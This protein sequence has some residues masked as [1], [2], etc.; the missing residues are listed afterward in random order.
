MRTISRMSGVVVAAVVLALGAGCSSSDDSAGSTGA[1]GPT[2]AAAGGGDAEGNCTVVSA[3]EVADITGMEVTDTSELPTGCQWAVGTTGAT[4]EW[5]SIPA[6]TYRSNLD[7]AEPAG[8]EVD[9]LNGI[10]AEGFLR[11]NT[12]P[13][14][15]TINGETWVL[16]GDTA[17]FVRS[18]ALGADQAEASL[19]AQRQIAELLEQRL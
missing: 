15:E 10:G 1:D 17:Y 18:G 4:Y 6:E 3:D 11:L 2:P 9:E 16:L 8:F 12:G 14:G 19:Q 7:S 5:Q 13:D